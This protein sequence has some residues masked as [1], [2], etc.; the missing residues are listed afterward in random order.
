MHYFIG[1]QRSAQR[2]SDYQAVL[3]LCSTVYRD[4]DVAR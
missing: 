4:D 2:C 1:P 3:L